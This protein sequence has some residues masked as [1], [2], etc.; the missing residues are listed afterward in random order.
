M[1]VYY[2]STTTNI[3]S[4]SFV[5]LTV[6]FNNGSS[7][8]ILLFPSVHSPSSCTNNH[9]IVVWVQ[10]LACRM[11]KN[12][13]QYI[14]EWDSI[15]EVHKQLYSSGGY[16]DEADRN[17]TTVINMLLVHHIITI[18]RNGSLSITANLLSSVSNVSSVQLVVETLTEYWD[19]NNY[20]E[21]FAHIW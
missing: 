15:L 5:L 3:I 7:S 6:H 20:F 16:Y 1:S 10:T 21:L 4:T 19:R 17:W 11:S 18:N 14:N 9:N 2:L 12:I 8:I 13:V